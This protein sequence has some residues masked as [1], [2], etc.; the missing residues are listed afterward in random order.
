MLAKQ[1]GHFNFFHPCVVAP[2]APGNKQGNTVES[3]LN[4]NPFTAEKIDNNNG[5]LQVTLIVKNSLT[6]L[7]LHS[8]NLFSGTVNYFAIL[9]TGF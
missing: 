9:L 2:Y 3:A 6:A 8:R 5:A 1:E 7:L 4:S